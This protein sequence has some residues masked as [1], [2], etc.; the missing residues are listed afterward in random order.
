M[1]DV[2]DVTTKQGGKI[3]AVALDAYAADKLLYLN[4]A[5]LIAVWVTLNTVEQL[6]DRYRCVVCVCVCV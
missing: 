4:D 2:I 6:R 5:R 1:V 3:A